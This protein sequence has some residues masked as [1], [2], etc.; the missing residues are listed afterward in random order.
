[1]KRC[2]ARLATCTRGWRARRAARSVARWRPISLR[3]RRAA[4]RAAG[5]PTVL[6]PLCVHH[7]WA[8]RF[9]FHEQWA[10]PPARTSGIGFRHAVTSRPIVWSKPATAPSNVAP[11]HRL[12]PGLPSGDRVLRPATISR[13]SARLHARAMR[14]DDRTMSAKHFR[15]TSPHLRA[16]A[17]GTADQSGIVLARARR[18]ARV[19]ASIHVAGASHQAAALPASTALARAERSRLG[20]ASPVPLHWRKKEP[21]SSFAAAAGSAGVAADHAVPRANETGAAAGISAGN[22]AAAAREVT[23]RQPLDAA[24]ADRLV[25]DVV[26]RIDKRMRIERER[27]GL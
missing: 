13:P 26:R 2:A 16:N 7:I 19:A 9:H 22:A 14:S 1:M 23:R 5:A 11:A 21:A 27:R 3:W 18:P 15:R 12:S 10:A 24:A 20:P 6:R 17:P 25:D 4:R 8:P